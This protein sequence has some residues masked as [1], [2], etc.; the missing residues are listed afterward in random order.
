MARLSNRV[1]TGREPIRDLAIHTKR[2]YN[3]SHIFQLK[4]KDLRKE[5]KRIGVGVRDSG[6]QSGKCKEDILPVGC[7]SEEASDLKKYLK[8]L[9]NLRRAPSKLFK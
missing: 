4:Q 5:N 1:N 8:M 2:K 7:K 9:Q 3:P 6:E